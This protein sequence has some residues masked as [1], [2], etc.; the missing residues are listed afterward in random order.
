MESVIIKVGD[1]LHKHP[2]TC[3]DNTSS[4]LTIGR[5]FSSD[6]VL[7]DPYIGPSQLELHDTENNECDWHVTITD[8]T[9]PVF[10][11]DKIIEASGF[12]I[13]SGD[14]ITIGRTNISIF[15][16]EHEV[17]KTRAFSFTN[18]LHNHKF[19]PLITTAMF[20]FLLAVT[21]LMSYLELTT[22]LVWTEM[23]IT[24]I[25]AA[26]LTFLWS[27][28]WALVGHL[29]KGNHHFFS[30]LFFTSISFILFLI[31]ADVASYVDYSFNSRL[32]GEIASWLIVILLSGVLFGFNLA[33][34]TYSPGAFRNG[35][36]ASICI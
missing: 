17:A 21:L 3:T 25:V 23:S 1:V 18:W 5:A 31:T 15:S 32:A 30:Q 24:I 27:S 33:L 14:E 36:I 11:N 34:V 8:N 16:S 19:K 4:I 10:L 6:V 35:L 2:N 13:C 26:V 7:T 12:D 22:E 20:L 9:N 28:G 29:L